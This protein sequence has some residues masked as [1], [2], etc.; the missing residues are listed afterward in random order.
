LERPEAID[1]LNEI[2]QAADGVMIAR[3]DLGVEVDFEK[4][5]F[6]QKQILERAA[7]RGKWA[8]VAT[9]MLRSMVHHPRPTRAEVTDV[10]NAVL[11][12]ADA[13]MLSEETATG[14]HPPLVIDAMMRIIRQ[15]DSMD[16][17][18]HSTFDADI[19]SFAAG[20]AGAAVSAAVRL[21]AKAIIAL[22]GSNVTALL[23]SKWRPR[24]PILA[25]SSGDSTLRRLNVL[26]GVVPVPIRSKSG[27]EEQIR[28]AD[29]LLVQEGWARVGDTVVVVGAIPLGEGRETNS[30]R[31]HRIRPREAW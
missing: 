4:V 29:E 1:N 9:E 25:L 17:G 7:V 6:I 8:I 5:P 27:M 21:E 13:V 3:G 2:L 11:D 26:R 18:V 28:M 19:M 30:I 10:A 23:L 16:Q 20:A 31:F 12:G 24:M 22:A 14:D 15:A